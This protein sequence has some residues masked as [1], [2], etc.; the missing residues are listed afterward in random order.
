MK[1][2][3][4]VLASDLGYDDLEIQDGTQASAAFAKM[5]L[6]ETP[7]WQRQRLREALHAYC[8]R[9]TEAMVRVFD[10]LG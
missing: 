3:L 9:D 10:A 2:V 7:H 6:D 1:S 4:P 8:G 5:I